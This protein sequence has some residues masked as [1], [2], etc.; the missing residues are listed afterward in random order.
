[1]KPHINP[2]YAAT[3]A[4]FWM[5]LLSACSNTSAVASFQPAGLP[6]KVSVDANG[7]VGFSVSAGIEFPTPLGVFEVGVVAEP[8]RFSEVES[9]LVVRVNGADNYYD[10]H[11]Q[12]FNVQF[13]SG[14]YRQ[15]NLQKTG[16]TILLELERGSPT[17]AGLGTSQS[18]VVPEPI[19]RS[20]I[21][22]TVDDKDTA[23]DARGTKAGWR[24]SSYGYLGSTNWTYATAAAEENTGVWSFDVPIAGDYLVEV[25]IP[26]RDAGTKKANYIIAHDGQIDQHLIDQSQIA[27]EWVALGVYHFSGEDA[28]YVML[29]DSTGEPRSNAIRIGF[30]AVR[31]TEQR[32]ASR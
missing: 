1:M 6:L 11:G 18:Q 31:L 2:R 20:L 25:F 7:K 24:R 21:Q 23:F 19:Q 5:L 30:D 29:S 15:I 27:N 8:I 3:L 28:E 17:E 9:L 4:A 32:G 16:S 14:Y 26:E 12:D 10:L 13:K 22:I